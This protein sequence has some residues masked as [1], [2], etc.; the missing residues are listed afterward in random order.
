MKANQNFIRNIS[1]SLAF[2]AFLGIIFTYGCQ[3]DKLQQAAP[4]EPIEAI[5]ETPA[6]ALEKF[7]LEYN[8]GVNTEGLS[9]EQIRQHYDEFMKLLPEEDRN[10][11]VEM[12][13]QILAQTP[14]NGNV[15]A[16]GVSS[17]ATETLLSNGVPGDRFGQGVATVGNKVYVGAPQEQKVFEYSNTGGSYTLTGEITPTGASDDFGQRVSVSG[18]WMAVSAP[19]SKQFPQPQ[20]PGQVFLFKKQGG[21]WVQKAI[22]NGPAGHLN[23]GASGVVLQDNKLAVTSFSCNT[24]GTSPSAISVFEQSGNSWSLSGTITKSGYSSWSA[25][26]MDEEGNRIVGITPGS[27]ARTVIFTDNGSNWVEEDEVIIGSFP[28]VAFPTDVA[29]SYN[30][31]ILTPVF[32][33]NKHWVIGN[34][35]GDW[36]IEQVLITPTGEIFSRYGDIEESTI[37]IGAASTNNSI[38]DAVH[39]F[40]HDGSSWVLFETLTPSDNGVDALIRDVAISGNTIVA[41][42]PGNTGFPG[43]AYVWD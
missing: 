16:Q 28:I 31:I 8:F 33:G 30:T 19:D 7:I 24:C 2:L 6:L 35:G 1:K 11:L 20:G 37:V 10:A 4:T 38:P 13:Q 43:K 3:K 32:P 29:I 5:D 9:D 23:F 18:S 39:V 21:S 41:G 15:T 36:E 42:L 22:L 40:N 27:P 26:D 14:S 34:N 12:V 17:R 25:I